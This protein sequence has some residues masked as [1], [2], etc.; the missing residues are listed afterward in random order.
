MDNGEVMLAA[1]AADPDD[2]HT[3]LV[4]ADWLE[5]QGQ[6]DEADRQRKWPAAKAYLQAIANEHFSWEDEDYPVD[7]YDRAEWLYQLVT[8]LERHDPNVEQFVPFDYPYEFDHVYSDE[9]WDHYEVY[10]GKSS[11]RSTERPP[12]RCGC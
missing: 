7:N 2:L 11:A 9:M 8:F 5:E 3:R 1:L 12:F 4:Y 10:T 6:G